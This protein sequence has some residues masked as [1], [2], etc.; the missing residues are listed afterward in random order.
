M[1]SEREGWSELW[2]EAPHTLPLHSRL[3][4]L[5]PLGIGTPLVEGLTSYLA[6]LAEAHSVHPRD[7]LIHELTPY[8]SQL[9]H[10]ATGQLKAGAMSRFLRQ[11]VALNGPTRTA[12][13]LVW[14]L[15]MLTG[16]N[17][18]SWLTFLPFTGVFS[19][20]KLLRQ[21]QAW[22]PYC[23]ESWR[24]RD[25]SMYE[26]LIWSFE[27]LSLCALHGEPFQTHCPFCRRA[28]P[29]LTS[30]FQPGYCPWCNRW[31]G[32]R[33]QER[34]RP[35]S[36][37]IEESWKQQQW[38]SHMVGEVLAVAP[39]LCQPLRHEDAL[40][41]L[42]AYVNGHVEGRYAVAARRLG[43]TPSTL[44]QWLDG[45]HLPQVRNL[46]QVCC[47]LGISLVSL[48]QGTAKAFS[49]TGER[50]SLLPPSEP[51]RMPFRKFDAE[52]IRL[53][54]QK[55]LEEPDLP[56]PSLNQVAQQLRYSPWWLAKLFPDL[57]H[58]ISSRYDAYQMEQ[59][60]QR[61]QNR[62]EEVRRAVL[63]LHAQGVH[64]SESRVRKAL[65]KPA[66]LRLPEIRDA[67]KT[68]LCEVGLG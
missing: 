23:F 15:E 21:T 61:H 68:A 62:C 59:R 1:Q 39:S 6:R 67:W 60:R 48:L 41:V 44:R 9:V 18:L 3:Y 13:S 31:V 47:A 38:I 34:T 55:A 14:G 53:A 4:H 24:E 63:H 49:L 20:R 45:N 35:F 66:I 17:D 42:V 25:M 58:A 52:V 50:P 12:R 19:L 56:P 43:L 30:Q 28:R 22:C 27:S 16:R 7:L 10:C 65:K 54:L 11:S 64:P 36:S 40:S 2:E 37:E 8:L 26:P 51:R 46:L 57:C 33:L 29:P 5:T 32:Q